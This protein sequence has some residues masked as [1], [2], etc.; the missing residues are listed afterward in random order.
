MKSILKTLLAS[1]IAVSVS[2]STPQGDENSLA[3]YNNNRYPLLQKTYMELPLGAI[4][5]N[6]ADRG[7]QGA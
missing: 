1:F 6:C 2:A 3:N 7:L 4:K 5:A